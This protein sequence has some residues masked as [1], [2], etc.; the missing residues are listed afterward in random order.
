[1]ALLQLGG[2]TGTRVI[3][4]LRKMQALRK[5]AK[6]RKH[7]HPL[8]VHALRVRVPAQ[9]PNKKPSARLDI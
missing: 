8:D 4:R 6:Q 5:A 9:Q 2:P 7:E 1:M 3:L